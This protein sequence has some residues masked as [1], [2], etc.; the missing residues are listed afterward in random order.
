[1]LSFLFKFRLFGLKWACMLSFSIL[2]R[3]KIKFICLKKYWHW[4]V[5]LLNTKVW[6]LSLSLSL[7]RVDLALLQLPIRKVNRDW[8]GIISWWFYFSLTVSNIPRV[9]LRHWWFKILILVW[10]TGIPILSSSFFPAPCG[11]K[12]HL[13][14]HCDR[15]QIPTHLYKFYF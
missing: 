8:V 2:G 7:F 6:L 5:V 15:M 3:F 4:S 14:P 9:V 13:F 10:G 11:K 1:M 12:C